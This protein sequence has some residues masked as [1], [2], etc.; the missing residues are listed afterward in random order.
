MR[1]CAASK[2]AARLLSALVFGQ[3]RSPSRLCRVCEQILYALL[4]R[5]F[6]P[7]AAKTMHDK[8]RSIALVTCNV[9]CAH[10]HKVDT[11]EGMYISTLCVAVYFKYLERTANSIVLHRACGMR[12]WNVTIRRSF[13]CGEHVSRVRSLWL[14]LSAEQC[15]VV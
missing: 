5:Q 4:A 14:T 7:Q 3:T 11:E 8:C 1:P 15:V 10:I 6:S 13:K 2:T 9:N 12:T